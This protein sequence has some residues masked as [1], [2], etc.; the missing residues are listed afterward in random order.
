MHQ[1]SDF[2]L[3]DGKNSYP[4]LDQIAYLRTNR[5]ALITSVLNC[6]RVGQRVEATCLLLQDKDDWACNKTP[7]EKSLKELLTNRLSLRDAMQMLQFGSVADYFSYRWSDP[8][9]LSG[10]MLL[11]T[12][13]PRDAVVMEL[14][15]GIGHYLGEFAKRGIPAVGCDVV[16]AK[17]WLARHYVAKD[18]S[19]VCFDANSYFPFPDEI[20][21]SVFCH[22]AFYFLREKEHV[23]NEMK[24]VAKEAGTILVGHS[25][26]SEADNFSAG[27]AIS[28]EEYTSLFDGADL[29]A[30][31]ELTHRLLEGRGLKTGVAVGCRAI[32]VAKGRVVNAHNFSMP[33]P[34]ETLILNPLL[35]GGSGKPCWP[36]KRYEDEYAALSSYLQ[37]DSIPEEVTEELIRRR[38]FLALP[39]RW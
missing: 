23:V 10:L 33:V 16:F 15:C 34:G 3:S 31:E 2:E 19:L 21:N 4:Y 32:S 9:F 7:D 36:S 11:Q 8:T 26:C 14:A 18:T 5:E 25:H 6:L 20:V 30:D 29:Y 37:V 24:R 17:L 27:Q 22:D 13:L 28:L 35:V 1:T 12:Y 38:V 39:E